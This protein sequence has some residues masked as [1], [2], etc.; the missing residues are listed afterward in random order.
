MAKKLYL[1]QTNKML[2]G[3]CGGLGEYLDIDPT[4]IR[5]IWA[6]LFFTGAGFIAYLVA[7]V[8]VPNGYNID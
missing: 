4:F 1:S 8:I 3:V 7:W 2:G 5:I 6:L